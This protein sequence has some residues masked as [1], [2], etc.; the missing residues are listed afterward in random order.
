MNR[1]MIYKNAVEIAKVLCKQKITIG[2][3]VIDA[4]MGNGNDTAFF[5][6]LVGERG[7]V[8]AFDIQEQAV[9]VTKSKLEEL[10]YLDRVEL[11]LRSHDQMD[12]VVKEKVQAIM[13]NLGYL[14]KGDHRIVTKPETS[15][16]A[17]QKSLELI[18]VNGIIIII[19]YP[20]HESGKKE[21][22]LI[23]NYVKDL[24]QKEFSVSHLSFCNQIN[25]PPEC[26]CIEKIGLTS[27]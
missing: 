6:S 15:L 16:A 2:D 12:E 20:G 18:A 24:P 21:K 4:T 17:L 8:Y 3:H 11:H 25:N 14:P 13:F 23:L 7:K 9:A 19:L 22:E 26:I 5:C 27:R 1:D 10:H